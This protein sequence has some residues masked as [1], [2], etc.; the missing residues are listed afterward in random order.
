MGRGNFQDVHQLA[1]VYDADELPRGLGDDLLAGKR[2][3]ASLDHLA[4]RVDLVCSV[5]VDVEGPDLVEAEHRDAERLE[6]L[7]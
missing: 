7:G 6:P 3:A 5:N 1:V 4:G 2:C